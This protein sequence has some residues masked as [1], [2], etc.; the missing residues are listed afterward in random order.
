MS[1]DVKLNYEIENKRLMHTQ[2]HAEADLKLTGN[3][4]IRLLALCVERLAQ[5]WTSG[6]L[7]AFFKQGNSVWKTSHLVVIRKL[8]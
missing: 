1:A 4:R 3:A 2:K 7:N 8:K 6:D 5:L